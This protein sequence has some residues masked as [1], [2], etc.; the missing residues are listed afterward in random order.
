MSIPPTISGPTNLPVV[1]QPTIHPQISPPK[2]ESALSGVAHDIRDPDQGVN[3]HQ[4]GKLEFSAKLLAGMAIAGLGALATARPTVA[5]GEILGFGGFYGALAAYPHVIHG[6]VKAKTGVNLDKAYQSS[7]GDKRPLFNDP[8]YL[9]LQWLS[10]NELDRIGQRLGVP[11]THPNRRGVIED[12][13]RGVL[14]QSQTWWMLSA[15][16]I[17][18]IAGSVMGRWL[19]PH[20]QRGLNRFQQR[21][22][23]R[24]VAK[25]PK[26]LEQLLAT[27]IG[28]SANSELA[29]WSKKLQQSAV[30]NL[31]L[32]KAFA[33][34]D[35][36]AQPF[37]PYH[38]KFWRKSNPHPGQHQAFA[39]HLVTTLINHGNN[40]HPGLVKFQ[41]QLTE[42][43]ESLQKLTAKTQT[44]ID[45]HATGTNKLQLQ[46]HADNQLAASR[47]Q[48]RHWNTL[49]T[50]LTDKSTPSN[51]STVTT[52]LNNTTVANIDHL[53]GRGHT[54]KAAQLLGGN[55]QLIDAIGHQQTGRSQKLASQLGG[56]LVEQLKSGIREGLNHR[57]FMRNMVGGIGGTVAVLSG[58]YY[59]FGLGKVFK[60]QGGAVYT[61]EEIKRKY[62]VSNQLEKRQHELAMQKTQ[63]AALAP[64]NTQFDRPGELKQWFQQNQAVIYALNLRTFGAKDLNGDGKID[65]EQHEQGTFLS[66]INRLDELKA[67]GVN[68]LHLLPINPPGVIKQAGNAGSVYATADYHA[69]NPQLTDKQSPLNIT[70]QARLFIDE[71]HKR[72]MK[73][74]VDVPS[75]AAYDLAL[76]RPD[77]IA[78]DEAG[79]T[80][81]P[82]T[83][84]DIVML[85]N[86]KNLQQYFEGFFNLMANDLGVDGFR[87]DV[88]R[89]RPNWFWQHFTHKYPNHAWLAES[90]VEEDASPLQNVPR[91]VPE[92]FLSLGFDSIYGQN[93]TFHQMPSGQAYMDY[94]S[95]VAGMF[96]RANT[97]SGNPP[98]PN[99]KSLIGSFLTHDDEETLM[100]HGGVPYSQMA[101]VLNAFQPYTNPYIIDGMQTGYPHRI[102]IFNYT[103]A[104]HG[105]NPELAT[106]MANVF[107]TRQEY[108]N[109]LAK[110]TYTP[111]TVNR[112]TDPNHQVMAYTLTA[113]NQKLLIIGN[114]D[115]NA[116]SEAVINLP[117]DHQLANL[118]PEYG[119]PSYVYPTN[120]GIHVN[121]GPARVLVF[122]IS[123]I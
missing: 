55:N 102:D 53:I 60:H 23:Q 112:T 21:R 12:R 33:K 51:Q 54:D 101:T 24:Q 41:Q 42:F 29:Q 63:R 72:G 6:L 121:L 110:G 90:Y 87:V 111:L 27:A 64:R 46:N 40:N 58:L 49:L 123:N 45:D 114:K 91:D 69:L 97:A 67:L 44:W 59:A 75:C 2:P 109:V 38:F 68:T 86:D 81:T 119:Q 47:A 19:E 113:G 61:P 95:D 82:A 36:T 9:P 30:A 94:L 108:A 15:G 74:M 4:L 31:G 10:D 50:Q 84:L 80:L 48:L 89:A 26:K 76:A 14:A 88:A 71:A 73:V 7:Q 100:D 43:E 99:G 39:E 103:P 117:V 105:S 104:H 25:S 17:V 62:D 77:L 78:A 18:P 96:Q 22:Y 16:P 92:D 3:A 98:I 32:T 5:L 56:T 57:R 35:K 65:P 122:D 120:Q 52:T 115:V 11:K 79:R 1:A 13:I 8:Q 37:S 85:K 70:E 107:K 116:R 106:F 93:H 118:V 66:A 28:H 20:A 83:W 34:A